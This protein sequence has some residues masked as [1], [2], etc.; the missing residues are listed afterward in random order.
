L[1]ERSV[2]SVQSN[3]DAEELLLLRETLSKNGEPGY[4]SA[5]GAKGYRWLE[6]EMVKELH[7]EDCIDRSY[8]NAL[9]DAA[10]KDIS[11]YGD[12]EWFAG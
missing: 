1:S 9:V 12:F 11:H 7:K 8:Y 4:S 10:V 2:L 5:V 3:P 6:S